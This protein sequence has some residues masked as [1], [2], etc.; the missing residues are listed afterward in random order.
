MRETPEVVKQWAKNCLDKAAP[1]GGMI[2]SL[3]G[4]VSMGTPSASPDAIL[5]AAREWSSE[6][7]VAVN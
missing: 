1:G 3:G 2:V 6:R 5:E 7:G 4:G